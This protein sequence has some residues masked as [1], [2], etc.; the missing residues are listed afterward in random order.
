ML[1]NKAMSDVQLD[2]RMI[3]RLSKKAH[4]QFYGIT[5]KQERLELEDF[6]EETPIDQ[7]RRSRR[8]ARLTTSE[9]L[10]IAHAA[11]VDFRKHTEIAKEFRIRPQRVS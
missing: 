6:A 11:L 9:Q 10:S 4:K 3:V 8:R 5:A 1:E 2:L 7:R